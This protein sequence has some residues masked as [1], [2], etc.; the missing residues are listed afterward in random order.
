VKI[1][2]ELNE[3]EMETLF[4]IIEREIIKHT[5]EAKLNFLGPQNRKIHENLFSNFSI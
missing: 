3:F 1:V 2:A 4:D 5:I